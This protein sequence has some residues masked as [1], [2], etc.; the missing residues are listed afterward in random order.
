[1]KK[2]IIILFSIPFFLL[3]Q[4]K[5]S[6]EVLWQFGR[7]SDPQISPNGQTVIYGVKTYDVKANKGSNIIYAKPIS[8][9]EAKAITEA[10]TNASGARFTPDGKKISYL[11]T[12]SPVPGQAA[13]DM[14]L[15]EMNVDGSDKKQITV[16]PGGISGYKYSPKMT[17]LAYTADVKLDKAAKEITLI[18]IKPMPELL[19]I[20]YTVIGIHGM[21]MPIAICLLLAMP[22]VQL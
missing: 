22:R 19:T 9:G 13:G 6:T 2:L 14:Q 7:L 8:G 21:I 12:E 4:N 10:K 16:F 5:L 17:Q 20:C 1:M 11:S 18:S 3:A 15:W